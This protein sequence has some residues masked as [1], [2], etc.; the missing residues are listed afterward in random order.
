MTTSTPI[1]RIKKLDL[2][3]EIEGHSKLHDYSLTVVIPL[4][5]QMFLADG[6]GEA[7][8]EEE[9]KKWAHDTAKDFV[10]LA[11]SH[12]GVLTATLNKPL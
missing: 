6:A 10:D 9:Y 5:K 4:T 2:A 1:K 8:T 11:E 12:Y 3:P 7:D